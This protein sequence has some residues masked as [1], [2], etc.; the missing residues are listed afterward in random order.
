MIRKVSDTCDVIGKT[1]IKPHIE[2]SFLSYLLQGEKNVLID[3]VPPKA[4]DNWNKEISGLLSGKPID[5][6]ILNHAE[7]DHSGSLNCILEKHPN[8]PIY[9]TS[10]CKDKLRPLFPNANFIPVRHHQLLRIG[11]FKFGFIHTPGLH[12]NDNMVTY[13]SNEQILFSNDLFGQYLGIDTLTDNEISKESFASAAT[14][15]FEKV[16]GTASTEDL[17][18]L[19]EIFSLKINKIA[20]GHGVIIEKRLKDI[21]TLYAL[22][23]P[24][25]SCFKKQK[26]QGA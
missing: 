21:T 6:V 17:H 9:C 1:I 3:T 15:Y 22:H 16:F 12:W 2:I 10:A 5:A 13:F 24:N 7:D 4:G 11:N 25:A 19:S 14:T 23:Y 18:I 8:V 20:P 26:N